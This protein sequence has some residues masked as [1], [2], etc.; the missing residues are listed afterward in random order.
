MLKI[1]DELEVKI[2]KLVNSGYGLAKLENFVIFVEHACPED[3]VKVKITKICEFYNK[4]FFRVKARPWTGFHSI[5]LQ[6]PEIW[7]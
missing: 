6:N 2:I 5:F 3:T 4:Y 7:R 1:G